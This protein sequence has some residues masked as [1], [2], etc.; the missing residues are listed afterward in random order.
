M[1]LVSISLGIG[2]TGLF[3]PLGSL[4]IPASVLLLCSYCLSQCWSLSVPPMN[5]KEGSLG[6][7]E[8]S[9][10]AVSQQL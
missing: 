1:Q 3:I 9:G 2:S 8:L 6:L 7:E 10:S 5:G 4:T